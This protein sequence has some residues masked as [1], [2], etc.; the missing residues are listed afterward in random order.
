[1][2]K[3]ASER[4]VN[5]SFYYVNKELDKIDNSIC[6]Y[7]YD[8]NKCSLRCPEEF[9]KSIIF[10]TDNLLSVNSF[11]V[12]D[13]ITDKFINLLY[14][15][16]NNNN[17]PKNPYNEITKNSDYSNLVKKNSPI[18]IQFIDSNICNDY[19]FIFNSRLTNFYLFNYID[20]LSKCNFNLIYDYRIINEENKFMNY[21]IDNLGKNSVKLFDYKIIKEY[22]GKNNNK[23]Y[24]RT[25][26]LSFNSWLGLSFIENIKNINIDWIDEEVYKL[27]K[28]EQMFYRF[29]ILTES[30]KKAKSHCRNF[31]LW[32]IKEKLGLLPLDKN[33]II[34]FTKN[35]L[36]KL[37]DQNLFESFEFNYDHVKITF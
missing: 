16:I 6:R 26:E 37:K 22:K 3:V 24:E 34:Q 30:S 8:T 36:S 19:K 12:I 7:K 29:F 17:I 23:T 5:R 14:K 9:K 18:T 1:M 11:K 31:S 21:P 25:Y 4:S 33:Y 13:I 32:K 15:R 27:S 20:E 28:M 2:K 10:K 35:I